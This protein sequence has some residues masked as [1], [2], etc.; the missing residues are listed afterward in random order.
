MLWPRAVITKPSRVMTLRRKKPVIDTPIPEWLRFIEPIMNEGEAYEQAL[1]TA[2]EAAEHAA[3][4]GHPVTGI[5]LSE[6]Q[7]EFA[8]HRI[9]GRNL[10]DL[11]T[12]E[13]TDY[14]Q[15]QGRYDAIVSIEMIEAVGEDNWPTYF[16]TLSRLLKPGGRAVIQAITIAPEHFERYRAKVDFIQRYVFP[17]GMLLTDQAIAGNAAEHGMTLRRIPVRK[18]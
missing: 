17:G 10:A 3:E 4:A 16:A 18:A 12:F 5:T 15:A 2:K 1:R 9:E 14:R 11:V 7:L 6:R 13:L 8:G